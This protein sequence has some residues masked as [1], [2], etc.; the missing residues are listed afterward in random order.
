MDSVLEK[1]S[2]ELFERGVLDLSES[3]IDGTFA[4]AKK[5]ACLLGKPKRAKGQRS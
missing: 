5:G 3:F 2:L 1:I 4:P